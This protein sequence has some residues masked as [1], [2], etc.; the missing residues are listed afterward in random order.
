[1]GSEIVMIAEQYPSNVYPWRELAKQTGAEIKVIDR[2]ENSD[3]TSSLEVAI[4]ENTSIVALPHCHWTDGSQIDL[5]RI[6]SIC[7]DVGAALV[8]DATQSLG[9]KP[10]SVKKIQP[11]FLISATY[12]WMLGPYSF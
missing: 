10:F 6:G 11:D 1:K 7:K 2:P 9:V 5:E 8:V 3:W 4:T 12:K